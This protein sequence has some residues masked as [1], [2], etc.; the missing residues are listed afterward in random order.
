MIT[1]EDEQA[2]RQMWEEVASDPEMLTQGDHGMMSIDPEYQGLFE[3]IIPTLKAKITLI[4]PIEYELHGYDQD[5]LHY[6]WQA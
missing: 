1:P 3:E 2:F 6:T 4:P 5:Q